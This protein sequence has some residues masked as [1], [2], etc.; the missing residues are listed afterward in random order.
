MLLDCGISY[1]ELQIGAGFSLTGLGGCLLTHEHGD[2]AKAARALMRVGVDVYA[3]SGTIR[4]LRL[5]GHRVHAVRAREPFVIGSWRVVPFEAIH[6]AEEPFG[7]VMA[8]TAG[9][10]LYLTDSAYCRYR[11][12]GLTHVMI[13]CNYSLEIM[14][15]RRRCGELKLAQKSRVLTNHLGLERVL[16]MLKANDL[17]AV[18][19]IHLLHLSDGNSD[20]ELFQKAV[21]GATG[22]PV[23]VAPFRI[24]V[25]K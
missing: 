4:I 3:S 5:D 12:K 21:Q 20:A 17:S 15:R 23:Y 6:D 2:H 16:E 22:K 1:R 25:A 19:E 14:R 9:R 11:V 18:R 13:E 8:S 10:V 24:G 7:F